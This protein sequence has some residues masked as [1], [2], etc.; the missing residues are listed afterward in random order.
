MKKETMAK[1]LTVSYML[2]AC[3]LGLMT[4]CSNEEYSTNTESLP[5]KEV[6][7]TLNIDIAE[8][9]ILP[10]Q[11]QLITDTKKEESEVEA[12]KPTTRSIELTVPQTGNYPSVSLKDGSKISVYLILYPKTGYYG[13]KVFYSKKPVELTVKKGKLYM[14]SQQVE[15]LGGN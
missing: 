2:L 8:I 10:A 4:S 13:Y 9:P 6:S 3:C 15:F 12:P 5:E 14:L 11:T 1:Y 7:Y